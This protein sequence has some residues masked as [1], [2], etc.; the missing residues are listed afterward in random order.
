MRSLPPLQR[1]WL[2]M[3]GQL[4]GSRGLRPAEQLH[5]FCVGRRFSSRLSHMVFR[6]EKKCFEM[7]VWDQGPEA[8]RI[9]EVPGN[10]LGGYIKQAQWE[11][12]WWDPEEE[13]KLCALH[14]AHLRACLNAAGVNPWEYE[15]YDG[16]VAA[17]AG[18]SCNV[19]AYDFEFLADPDCSSFRLTPGKELGG[20]ITATYRAKTVA[21][22]RAHFAARA[23]APAPELRRMLPAAAFAERC[24]AA[25]GG[26]GGGGLPIG[27]FLSSPMTAAASS[28][29]DGS[30]GGGAHLR[31][32]V[33]YVSA[34]SGAWDGSK[35]LLGCCFNNAVDYG[36]SVA[37][38]APGF[39]P[40]ARFLMVPTETCKMGP[41]TLPPAAVGAMAAHPARAALKRVLEDDIGQ[42]TDLKRGDAQ[43]LFDAITVMPL[44]TLAEHCGIVEA[45]VVFGKNR[46]AIGTIYEELGVTLRNK[47]LSPPDSPK[48]ASVSRIRSDPPVPKIARQLSAASEAVAAAAEV[49]AESPLPAD[50]ASV[51]GRVALGSR[52]PPGAIY[53]T[54]RVFS[55][56][57]A[58]AFAGMVQAILAEGDGA[59]E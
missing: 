35:N 47:A 58:A 17:K 42:W 44:A 19:H 23:E 3:R 50:L 8:P 5:L 45:S 25:G 55:E 4:L 54:E 21:E 15:I 32:R 9:E 38:C 29:A 46:F 2:Q 51:P 56:G 48:E 18:L 14:A 53:A 30:T 40:A 6:P 1:A 26:V 13:R 37:C 24:L 28:F 7:E 49:A 39:F 52:F 20:A 43:P 16:G 12:Q 57:C 31:E 10:K 34:M 59:S 27:L 11:E 36:A 33:A 22:R 41:F